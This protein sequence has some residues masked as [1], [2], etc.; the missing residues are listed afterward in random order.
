MEMGAPR[1]FHEGFET[2]FYVGF[3]TLLGDDEIGP[4]GA[5]SV[6]QGPRKTRK[7]EP[8]LK[9]F[10]KAVYLILS[11]ASAAQVVIDYKALTPFVEAMAVVH[12]DIF[13]AF[14]AP[15]RCGLGYAVIRVY[16]Y[17]VGCGGGQKGGFQPLFPYFL[18]FGERHPGWVGE[19]V[20]VISGGRGED[21]AVAYGSD[22]SLTFAYQMVERIVE[23]G[24][25]G[26]ETRVIARVFAEVIGEFAVVVVRFVRVKIPDHAEAKGRG[27]TCPGQC[28]Q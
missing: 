4:G 18:P 27:L 5:S 9:Q 6:A 28:S 13:G 17:E 21:T 15:R 24:I 19:G 8:L 20:F 11:R 1:A 23:I 14:L 2:G 16:E 10:S 26:A 3:V 25:T 7:T 12:E 22:V